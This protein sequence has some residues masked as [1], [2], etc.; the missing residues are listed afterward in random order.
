M[1][2]PLST[3]LADGIDLVLERYERRRVERT[4]S[5]IS[6]RGHASRESA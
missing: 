3:A 6:S 1:T 2:V 5:S 4:G